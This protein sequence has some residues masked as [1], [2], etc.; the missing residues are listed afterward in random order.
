MNDSCQFVNA[1]GF[2]Y[3]SASEPLPVTLA[4]PSGDQPVRWDWSDISA[5]TPLPIT[6]V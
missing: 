4:V 6:V 2:A 1:N 5:T 3:V